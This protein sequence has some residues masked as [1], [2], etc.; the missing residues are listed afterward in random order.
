MEINFKGSSSEIILLFVIRKKKI[1][2]KE[3]Y[4][5]GVSC[6]FKMIFRQHVKSYMLNS[7]LLVLGSNF[8]SRRFLTGKFG[9]PKVLDFCLT[10]YREVVFLS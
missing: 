9:V 2:L 6:F 5:C 4:S 10:D 7:K 1:K 3:V 8:V